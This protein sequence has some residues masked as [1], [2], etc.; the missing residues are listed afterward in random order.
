MCDDQAPKDDEENEGQMKNN[1][2]VGEDVK[3]HAE[4]TGGVVAERCDCLPRSPTSNAVDG[5]TL[6]CQQNLKIV[7]NHPVW[8]QFK[9]AVL[10]VEAPSR[11]VTRI[12]IHADA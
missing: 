6:S 2:G 10:R 4:I 7:P 5:W 3:S 9:S 12:N 8:V 11:C 1:Y